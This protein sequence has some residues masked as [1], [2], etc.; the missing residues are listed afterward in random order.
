[1]ILTRRTEKAF[2]QSPWR[3]RN[4]KSDSKQH[5]LSNHKE[6]WKKKLEKK[7]KLKNNLGKQIIYLLLSSVKRWGNILPG[8]K[9]TF[10]FHKIILLDSGSAWWLKLLQKART[11]I[12]GGSGLLFVGAAFKLMSLFR[13]LIWPIFSQ[14][15]RKGLICKARWARHREPSHNQQDSDVTNMDTVHNV[16]AGEWVWDNMQDWQSLSKNKVRRKCQDL[17]IKQAFRIGSGR[18]KSA[19]AGAV[20]LTGG[21]QQVP[22]KSGGREHLLRLLPALHRALLVNLVVS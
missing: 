1:M 18:Y 10:P 9:R 12:S 21:L 14:S 15:N 17:K 5:A 22:S 4:K 11:N 7:K 13:S 8:Q 3:K 6:N 2:Y 16:R 19:R 20:Q